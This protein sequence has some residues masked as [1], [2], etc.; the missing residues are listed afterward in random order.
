MWPRLYSICG[1]RWLPFYT[2]YKYICPAW[3]SAKLS[4]NVPNYGSGV[5]CPTICRNSRQWESFHHFSFLGGLPIYRLYCQ[6]GGQKFY[7]MKSQRSRINLLWLPLAR[8]QA[9]PFV[10]CF[11]FL[12]FFFLFIIN[13]TF[14]CLLRLRASEFVWSSH[15]YSTFIYIFMFTRYWIVMIIN[16]WPTHTLFIV[17]VVDI[18][19]FCHYAAYTVY[20]GIISDIQRDI[21]I[22]LDVRSSLDI[23]FKSV[24]TRPKSQNKKKQ[25]SLGML[26]TSLLVSF[27]PRYFQTEPTFV[28]L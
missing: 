1:P 28:R 17:I 2:I 21:D 12:V 10:A 4:K 19:C 5:D 3:K 20:A 13:L 11:F 6:R 9:T 27:W 18:W 14:Y 8:L 26:Q 23:E 7:I 15:S 24:W 25:K 16:F 22:N